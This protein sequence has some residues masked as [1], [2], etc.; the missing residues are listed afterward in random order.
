MR[1]EII[2]KPTST[3]PSGESGRQAAHNVLSQAQR[4]NAG[5]CPIRGGFA[6]ITLKL[7]R[8]VPQPGVGGRFVDICPFND[9]LL[10]QQ[11]VFKAV[12]SNY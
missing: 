6:T 1:T 12:P 5:V 11:S 3:L 7:A 8:T 2:L 4:K 10:A 9:C